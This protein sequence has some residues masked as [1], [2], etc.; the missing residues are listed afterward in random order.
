M[1]KI[2]NVNNIDSK[3]SNLSLILLIVVIILMI[4]STK[5]RMK[6]ERKDDLIRLSKLFLNIT[7]R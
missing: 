7:L 2:N 5:A 4:Q 6:V 1:Y 3:R